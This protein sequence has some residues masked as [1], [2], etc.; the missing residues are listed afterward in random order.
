[1]SEW[2]PLSTF[3]NLSMEFPISSSADQREELIFMPGVEGESS[4]P[5]PAW[6]RRADLGF[7]AAALETIK[8]VLTN[9]AQTFSAMTKEGGFWSPLAYS[10]LLSWLGI[11]VSSFYQIVYALMNPAAI[12]ENLQEVSK[13][14]LVFAFIGLLLFMPLLLVIG[15]FIGA[16]FMHFFLWLMGAARRSFETTFRVLC[17]TQGSTAILQLIPV[18]GSIVSTFWYFYCAVV[19]LA[20]AHDAETWRVV[21]AV[22][23]PLV[24]FCGFLITIL[25]LVGGAAV[26]QAAG[27]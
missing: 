5:Q 6:E 14:V 12:D 24:L 19:G 26:M 16:A 25:M 23:L 2:K 17:Y 20:K 4:E 10:V 21:V 1:M 27:S 11:V 7:F 18:C 8:Q 9:P 13:S 22:L 3:G 15:A